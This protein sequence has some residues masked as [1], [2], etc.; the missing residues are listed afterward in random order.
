MGVYIY[1]PRMY[2]VDLKSWHDIDDWFFVT[3]ITFGHVMLLVLECSL[4]TLVACKWVSVR[5]HPLTTRDILG[6][7]PYWIPW[8][9][10]RLG[11]G[12]CWKINRACNKGGIRWSVV[13][14]KFKWIGA[15][16]HI[17]LSDLVIPTFNWVH[18]RLGIRNKT[19]IK[20]MVN[21]LQ[22]N[23]TWITLMR[24]GSILL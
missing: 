16:R 20:Q 2:F 14:R 23:P 5:Y 1:F 4:A 6:I 11:C 19:V 3:K 22:Q 7:Q 9:V 12:K 15:G 10:K 21:H 17:L 24:C 8:T 18:Y 13:N